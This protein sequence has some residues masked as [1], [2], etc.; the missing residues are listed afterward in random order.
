[1]T[2]AL[3]TIVSSFLLVPQIGYLG[4]AIAFALSGFTMLSLC[5]YFG[6]K[7][8]PV[9]YDVTSALGYI[10]AG[11]LLIYASTLFKINDLMI[12]VP[13]HMAVLAVF[14]GCVFLIERRNIPFLKKK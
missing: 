2:G 1:L 12:S 10:G 11:T 13:V 6:Q 8:Y 3:I 5:Y 7:Y 14:L 9:P 4:F